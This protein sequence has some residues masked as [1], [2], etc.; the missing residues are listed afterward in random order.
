M[1]ENL[2]EYYRDFAEQ[3]DEMH[4]D[5]EHVVSLERA[6]QLVQPLGIKSILDVGCGTGRA[7][8]WYCE[9]IPDAKLIGIDPSPDL[10]RRAREVLPDAELLEGDGAALPFHG[11]YADLVVAT[12]VMHHVDDPAECIQE[13]FR[14]A[15]KAVLISDHNNFAFGGNL[16]KRLRLLLYSLSLAKAVAFVKQGFRRQG[17]SEG[18]GWWYPYS[19]LDDFRLISHLAREVYILPVVP[20]RD[21]GAGNLLL[22][23]SHLA[24]LGLK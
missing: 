20:A 13:M 2:T 15:R 1:N 9:R 14:V 10:L 17:Y 23:Q 4:V 19:L 8:R 5:V 3:Y 7:L 24:V 6:T 21:T 16:K 11:E 22:C 18:D 12:A